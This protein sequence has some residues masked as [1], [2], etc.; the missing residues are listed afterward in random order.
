MQIIRRKAVCKKLGGINPS[1]LWRLERN[2]PSFPASVQL[3]GGIVGWFEHDL[4]H[5][6]E[7]K[8]AKRHST[9]ESAARQT[10]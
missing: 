7:S 9:T 2:D 10:P 1:T 6:L 8:T 4:D 5:W 3:S